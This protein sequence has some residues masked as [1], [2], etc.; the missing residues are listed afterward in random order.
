VFW[1]G[2]QSVRRT[3][4]VC[5]VDG[6]VSL[7]VDFSHSEGKRRRVCG[8]QGLKSDNGVVLP[9]RRLLRD[10]I[11]V[12][13]VDLAQ[14]YNLTSVVDVIDLGISVRRQQGHRLQAPLAIS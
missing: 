3:I 11:S 13:I 7:I 14:S 2:Q 4:R 10:E 1:N 6:N 12:V 5:C 9:K 8:N